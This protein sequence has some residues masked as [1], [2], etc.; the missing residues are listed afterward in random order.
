MVALGG[1]INRQVI[2]TAMVDGFEFVAM[3]RALLM[4]PDLVRRMAAGPATRSACTHC[5]RC[6]P[7]QE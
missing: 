6:M 7:Q 2:E 4:E 3:C 1:I 5:N